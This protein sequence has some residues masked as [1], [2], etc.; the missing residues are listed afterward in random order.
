MFDGAYGYG[1][2]FEVA[3]GTHALTTL[4]NFNGG[5]GGNPMGSLISDPAG[6]LYGTTGD[7]GADNDGTVFEIAADTDALTT[8][9]SFDGSNGAIPCDGLFADCAGDLYGTT[10]Q[11]GA[12]G[13]GTVFELVNAPSAAVTTP[14]G[15]Q[16]GNVAISYTL[17]DPDS[18]PCSIQV[19][20]SIDGGS[21]WETAA[22]G[23]GGDGTTSLT[24]SPGGTLHTFVWA[25][26]T[27][28]TDLYDVQNNSVQFRIIPSSANGAG[29]A[30]ATGAFTVDNR[31]AANVTL[32]SGPP[33]INYDGT[34]DVTNWA[35]AAVTGVTGVAA[36]TGRATLVFYQGSAAQ[37]T[38]LSAPPVATGTYTVV[39]QYAGDGNYLPATSS[40]VT[41]T[42]RLPGDTNLDGVVNAASIDAIYAHFG[43]PCTSQ[44][45]VYPDTKP[46]GQE[47]V[48]YE[49]Q[50]ILHTAYGDANLDC[51]VDFYDFQQLLY[52]WMGHY[53]WAGGDFNGDGVV[54]YGDFQILL[55]NW[56]PMGFGLGA[57]E[58]SVS[59]ASS[60][61]TAIAAASPSTASTASA[62]PAK[63]SGAV[64]TSMLVSAAPATTAMTASLSSGLVIQAGAAL[65]PAATAVNQLSIDAAAVPTSGTTSAAL[66]YTVTVQTTAASAASSLID[67]SPTSDGSDVDLLTPLITPV[68]A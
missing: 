68:V 40:A 34:S 31:L 11:G 50:N 14:V 46:V 19:Q 42:I 17:T 13:D 64:T 66:V 18:D 1:T 7:G 45:K 12:N 55:D 67:V 59:A 29:N 28:G 2:V 3:A 30:A 58:D 48:T 16:E 60:P 37:G 20:Y 47:D 22:P 63:A 15:R 56:N 10:T 26:D 36:P 52:H 27:P 6:N 24:S 25:A 38:P 43:A 54:D 35:V 44:W 8:L 61:S 9:V 57:S 33:Y 41:F 23:T 32:S 5:N 62:A 39:A 51:K 4:V 21:T 65:T 53:D 49:V